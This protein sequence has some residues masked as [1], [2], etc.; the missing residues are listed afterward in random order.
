MSKVSIKL[1]FTFR[2]GDLQTNQY[3]RVDLAVDQI[4]TELPLDQQLD[5][6]KRTAEGVWDFVKKKVD[7]QIDEVLD[8]NE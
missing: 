8:E 4:A 7:S 6:V 5:D 3:G 1:G 2:V